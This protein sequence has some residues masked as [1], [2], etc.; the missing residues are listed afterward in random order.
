MRARARDRRVARRLRAR[1]LERV[2]DLGLDLP[3]AAAGPR[4][5]HGAHVGVRR[6]LARAPDRLELRP[7]SCAGA[8]RGGG[9]WGRRPRA[10]RAC[11]ACAI[12]RTLPSACTTWRVAVGV[13]PERVVEAV[14]ALEQLG[15]LRVELLDE[16]RLVGAELGLRAVDPGPDAVPRLALAVAL[17][18]EHHDRVRRVARDAGA[19]PTRAR[20]TR[21]GTRGRCSAGSRSASRCC[22]STSGAANTRAALRSPILSIRR[23]RR[24]ANTS[25][26]SCDCIDGASGNR[27]RA[28][29]ARQARAPNEENGNDHGTPRGTSS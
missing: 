1:A 28:Y 21:S 7:A 18:D 24:S 12:A 25:L 29:A 10:G 13:E 3:L 22:G 5:L 6:D 20:R 2:L 14:G 17:A 15:E 26:G 8:A 11:P 4:G 16:E 9:P 23:R 19:A 27:G